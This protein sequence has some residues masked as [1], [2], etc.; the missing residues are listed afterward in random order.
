MR[1]ESM[2]FAQFFMVAVLFAQAQPTAL[3]GVPQAE[4]PAKDPTTGPERTNR[5]GRGISFSDI[6]SETSRPASPVVA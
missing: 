4:T 3:H 1:F 5:W 6:L 2:A